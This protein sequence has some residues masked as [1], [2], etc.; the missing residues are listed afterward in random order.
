MS[1]IVCVCGSAFKGK[2]A[3]ARAAFYRHKQRYPTHYEVL[4]YTFKD[5]RVPEAIA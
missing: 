2:G 1:V 3:S 5:P 4:R